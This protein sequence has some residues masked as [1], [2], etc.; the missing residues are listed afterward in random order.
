MTKDY[1]Q[2]WDITSTTDEADAV[3]TLAK[4]VADSDCRATTLRLGSENAMLY[5]ET[6]DHVSCDR[7]LPP[8]PLME[9]RQGLAKH[10]LKP[11][12][13]DAFSL[14]LR[15]LSERYGRL[16]DRMTIQEEIVVSDEIR[17]VGGFGVVRYGTYKGRGVAVK[18]AKIESHA[19]LEKIRKVRNVSPFAPA[20]GAAS[21]VLPQRFYREVVLWGRLSHPNV[22]KLVGAQEDVKKKEFT[23]V[24]EWMEHGTIM[25]YIK[26][27]ST[28]RLELVHDFTFPATLFAK[29]R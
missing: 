21:T 16:P 24:S 14:T 20:Q 15:R 5:I 22:L 19:D 1:R 17:G 25:D 12:E 13:K 10:N 7:H 11:T 9:Y 29:M 27:N 26:K 18:T 4:I 2:L 6:L 23:T 8:R 28:N 3:Q